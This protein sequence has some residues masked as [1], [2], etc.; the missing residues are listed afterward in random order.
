MHHHPH[1]PAE[2]A[3]PHPIGTSDADLDPVAILA[4]RRAADVGI[5]PYRVALALAIPVADVPGLIGEA[6]ELRVDGT[7]NYIGQVAAIGALD[8]AGGPRLVAAVR[9]LMRD[10]VMVVLDLRP[11]T[12]CDTAGV[13]AVLEAD[14]AAREADGSLVIRP[15]AHAVHRIF[16]LAGA[17]Q[18]LRIVG[19]PAM[20]AAGR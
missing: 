3:E 9:L 1:L 19:P 11:L 8:A 18:Q 5:D 16:E 2:P 7:A 12:L 6:L 10:S 17:T 15:A 13:Q 14:A 20:G 4:L